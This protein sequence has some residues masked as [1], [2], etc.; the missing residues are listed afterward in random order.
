MQRDGH[1]CCDRSFLSDAA[2]LEVLYDAPG[3]ETLAAYVEAALPVP[4][5]IVFVD[6]PP[7]EATRRVIERGRTAQ[8]YE[9]RYTLGEVYSAYRRLLFAERPSWLPEPFVF[10]NASKRDLS[11]PP[12]ELVDAVSR[13]L[14]AT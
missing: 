9:N 1:V 8:H 14:T 5:L 7:D 13:C 12:V 10:D 3:G 4:D 11:R 2:Y 6:T